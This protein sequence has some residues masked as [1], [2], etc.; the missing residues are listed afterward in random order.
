M[1]IQSLKHT[2]FLGF[3]FSVEKKSFGSLFEF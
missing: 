3:V 2:R 1:N